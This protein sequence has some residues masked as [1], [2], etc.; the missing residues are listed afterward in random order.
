MTSRVGDI[1]WGSVPP[2]ACECP[3]CGAPPGK[4]C[5]TRAGKATGDTHAGRHAVAQLEAWRDVKGE[6]GERMRA[7]ARERVRQSRRR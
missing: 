2:L 4:R 3:R 5:R 6:A 7:Q 1:L